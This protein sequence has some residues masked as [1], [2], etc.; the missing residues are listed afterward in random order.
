M[1]NNRDAVLC[2]SRKHF[3]VSESTEYDI[4]KACYR[5]IQ[6][7]H[8]RIAGRQWSMCC[9]EM[10]ID[11]PTPKEID[12]VSKVIDKELIKGVRLERKYME[13]NIPYKRSLAYASQKEH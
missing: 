10:L 11:K 1:L 8:F 9:G 4:S 13:K 2:Q 12:K 5:Y 7:V 3:K 6:S